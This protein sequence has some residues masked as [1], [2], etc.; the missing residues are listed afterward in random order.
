MDDKIVPVICGAS[1]NGYSIAR[2]F[3]ETYGIK[4][5]FIEYLQRAT[6]FSRIGKYKLVPDPKSDPEAFV[7]E[8]E[9]LGRS[10]RHDGKVPC[11]FVTNDE[12][13]IPLSKNKSRLEDYFIYSFPE[14]PII[15][16]LTYKP[17][18]L[19]LAD[20]LMISYPKSVTIESTSDIQHCTQQLMAPLILK[21]TDLVQ[22]LARFPNEYRNNLFHSA[23]D[24]AEYIVEK[25]ASGYSGSFLL[26]E[27]IP[28]GCENLFTVSTFS[29]K[30][31]KVRGVS[32]G[33]KLTQN[34]PDT[35]TITSGRV[36]YE[37][38][39]IEP[40]RSLLE[41]T[42]FYGIANTE[43]K[44]DSRRDEF[45]LIEVNPRPGMW[46][47][48]SYASGVN[49]FKQFIES[50]VLGHPVSYLEGKEEL[51][52]SV[53]DRNEIAA[54]CPKLSN[55]SSYKFVDPLD[56]KSDRS[57]RYAQLT[58]RLKGFVKRIPGTKGVFRRMIGKKVSTNDSR[59]KTSNLP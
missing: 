25:F 38:R 10:L 31:S 11:L 7:L 12:W 40:T 45:F 17:S 8:I 52:W 56:Y 1:V 59:P 39:I 16:K 33:H 42:G 19:A 27:F 54:Q 6:R 44:Y 4:S 50:F 2:T 24:V 29:D 37:P 35:G 49:F 46:N 41:T 53:I 58:K 47:Y 57:F 51:V 22:F 3:H 9:A 43:Y 36:K 21:P 55:L 5:L 14:W 48:S 34:P 32:I 30:Y 20:S 15:E 13:L 28:G 26:Q 23:N 18:L